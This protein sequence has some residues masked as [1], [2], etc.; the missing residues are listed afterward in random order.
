MAKSKDLIPDFMMDNPDD[1]FTF[2]M[3]VSLKPDLNDN[4]KNSLFN[5]FYKEHKTG[6][7]RTTLVA[8]ELFFTHFQF[9]V[10]YKN[11]KPEKKKFQSKEIRTQEYEINID[12]SIQDNV[13]LG[14]ILDDRLIMQLLDW[15]KDHV[16]TAKKI[17]CCLINIDG[18]NLIIPHYAIA[19]YYYY[20]STDLREAIL[21]CD[22]Q[23]LYD[24]VDCD[25]SN[26]S[27]VLKYFVTDDDAPFIHRFACQKDAQI[28]V[29][30]L[31]T[32]LNAY[33]RTIKDKKKSDDHN[34]TIENIPIKAMFPKQGKFTIWG[35]RS[36]FLHG[37][38]LYHFV[39]EIVNDN[40]DIGFSKFTAY[41]QPYVPDDEDDESEQKSPKVP[42]DKPANTTPRLGSEAGSRKYRQRTIIALRKQKCASLSAVKM[43]TELLPPKKVKNGKINIEDIPSEDEV[44]QGSTD[45]YEGTGRK[46]RKTNVSSKPQ[47]EK[48]KGHKGNFIAFRQYIEYLSKVEGVIN[49]Q[50][51]GV[52]KMPTV[53]NGKD[54]K[55]NPKCMVHGREREYITATFKYQN[56]YIGLLELENVASTST[57]VISSKHSFGK[58][59]FD[60][61]LK[62]YIDDNYSIDKI[63][64]MYD[65]KKQ[66]RF[67]T[68]NHEHSK[69]L[70]EVDLIRWS[71]GVLGK[72]A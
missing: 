13:K 36:S 72:L 35:R 14:D 33:M 53:M 30:R 64:K 31:G 58:G 29:D 51:Y 18:F 38:T 44:D 65:K 24:D 57:W 2:L 6:E 8:P 22:L 68:K 56:S 25:P 28:A 9:Q 70:T 43:S 62:H 3:P 52:Q 32:F 50:F 67:K 37:N 71:A 15:N 39:H 34:A 49:F 61:F 19:I 10:V 4:I 46:R 59:I 11:G 47:D 63:K 40:S 45:S 48:I 60:Q 55:A 7:I 26:A 12:E 66:I 17:S 27:I 5:V 23:S 41:Y 42:L 21:Q 16:K 69:R 20:R 54:G 1:L